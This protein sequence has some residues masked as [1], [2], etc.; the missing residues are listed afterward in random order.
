MDDAERDKGDF[1]AKDLTES[2]GQP[3]D[4]KLPQSAFMLNSIEA[5]ILLAA[6]TLLGISVDPTIPSKDKER[7]LSATLAAT[8]GHPTIS[9]DSKALI[10]RLAKLNMLLIQRK[11][12]RKNG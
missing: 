4:P 1:I 7:M 9:R 12:E 3:R 11:Q 5:A 2:W 10:A 6:A 8:K